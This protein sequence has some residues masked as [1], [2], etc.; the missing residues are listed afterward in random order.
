MPGAELL[1]ESHECDPS[2]PARSRKHQQLRQ[3]HV[4][5]VPFDPNTV[6]IYDNVNA[7]LDENALCTALAAS[8]S[9]SHDLQNVKVYEN[10]RI[11]PGCIGTNDEKGTDI[12]MD[13]VDIYRNE[14]Y[15]ETS[16]GW[17][18]LFNRAHLIQRLPSTIPWSATMSLEVRQKTCLPPS[19]SSRARKQHQVIS[20]GPVPL[21]II[22]DPG[23]SMPGLAVMALT[24]PSRRIMSTS[25]SK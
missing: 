15:W 16:W 12:N 22:R 5:R 7:N 4:K 19:T 8:G 20:N 2:R 18:Y 6:E 13:T 21:I 11:N 10:R 3:H 9:V 23:N 24:S 17:L 1:P 25:P 14:N